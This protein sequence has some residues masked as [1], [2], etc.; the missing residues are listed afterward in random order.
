MTQQASVIT[1]EMRAAI[2]RESEA[3][4]YEIDNTG[5][6]QFARSAGY[7]DPVFYDEG[8]ARSKGYRGILAPPG[9]LG[10]PVF[11]PAQP[12]RIPEA[13][14]LDVPFKRILNGGTDVEYFDDVCSGDALAATTKLTD[15]TERE[16]RMGKMLILQTETTARNPAGQTVAIMRGTAIRY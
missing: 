9:F 12:A 1:D 16:G 4:A 7:T 3:V 5:C 10:H 13:F 2:G 14:R 6:R 8:Y 15:L 11:N